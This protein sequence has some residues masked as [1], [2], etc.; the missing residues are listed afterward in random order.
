MSSLWD[1]CVNQLEAAPNEAAV[2]AACQLVSTVAGGTDIAP[3]ERLWTLL[4]RSSPASRCTSTAT[5]SAI[6]S[7]WP[8]AGLAVLDSMLNSS[9]SLDSPGEFSPLLVQVV[10]AAV[11]RVR[12]E[13]L[14]TLEGGTAALV[15]RVLARCC[16]VFF[17]SSAEVRADAVLATNAVLTLLLP[18]FRDVDDSG[19]SMNRSLLV[20]A[21]L[22]CSAADDNEPV[23]RATAQHCLRTFARCFRRIVLESDELAAALVPRWCFA[24]YVGTNREKQ[25]ALATWLYVVGEHAPPRPG[26][27]TPPVSPREAAV[28]ERSGSLRYNASPV[29]SEPPASAS[30]VMCESSDSPSQAA[31]FRLTVPPVRPPQAAAEQ[32]AGRMRPSTMSPLSGSAPS[33]VND[34]PAAPLP[35][36]LPLPGGHIASP[37]FSNTSAIGLQLLTR[38]LDQLAKYYLQLIDDGH[39]A[40]VREAAANCIGELVA[41]ASPHQLLP[42]L[43]TFMRALRHAFA[44]Q[45]AVCDAAVVAS[46]KLWLLAGKVM[47]EL[48]TAEGPA[49]LREWLLLT[50]DATSSSVRDHAAMGVGLLLSAS[51]CHSIDIQ[52]GIDHSAPK[53]DRLSE[54]RPSFVAMARATVIAELEARATAAGN[55]DFNPVSLDGAVRLLR[56]L[57]AVGVAEDAIH[58]D[59]AVSD[60][61]RTPRTKLQSAD[62]EAMQTDALSPVPNLP[63]QRSVPV[64]G[65]QPALNPT[66]YGLTLALLSPGGRRRRDRIP[67]GEV[68]VAAGRI[69]QRIFEALSKD[70][71]P[72]EVQEAALREV[73][74]I[75]TAIGKTATKSALDAV[76]TIICAC[77]WRAARD[78][79][80]LPGAYAA[81]DAVVHLRAIVGKPIFDGHL[82]D[83]QAACLAR[84]GEAV[85]K[86]PARA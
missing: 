59:D 32:Q 28:D 35:C 77:M 33:L 7:A 47:P 69:F 43:S 31:P 44:A 42:Y 30:P 74:Q 76:L 65:V 40:G 26:V 70:G 50:A 64:D 11:V 18:P 55:A 8:I 57:A 4:S 27:D 68:I 78:P 2:V 81:G 45:P 16:S 38:Y 15:D 3:H 13:A 84:C 71:T 29:T 52:T 73:P 37:P 9:K 80:A 56:E 67:A 83:E 72:P 23:V 86:M 41:R 39:D 85:P 6:T 46:G 1:I 82:T 60:A 20:A 58:V 49:L 24:R 54:T 19:A 34:V 66:R 5:L 62:N 48:A 53:S 51:A 36:P 12:P 79:S 63:T 25:H 10:I 21:T 61:A 22:V 17:R 14:T 75:A